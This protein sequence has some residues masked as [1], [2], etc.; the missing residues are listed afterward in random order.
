MDTD[1]QL[2]RIV[3]W[4]DNHTRDH[5][6]QRRIDN[7]RWIK[8]EKHLTRSETQTRVLSDLT[9]TVWGNGSD[10]LDKDVDR[11]KEND[12]RRVWTIRAILGA[13]GALG[14]KAVWALLIT[15]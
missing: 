6:E 8:I 15:L 9:N 4:Q 3:E 14:V 5:N 7:D 13:V 12:K 2:E 1:K 11:L 10:G